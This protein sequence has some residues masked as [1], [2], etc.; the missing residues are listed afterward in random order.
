MYNLHSHTLLSDGVLL[1]SELAMRHF[2]LGYKALA[3]TDHVDYSNIEHVTDSI[4]R[5][6]KAW[7]KNLGIKVLSGI[8]LTHLPLEQVG[9]LTKYARKKGIQVIVAHGQTPAEPVLK[10][11]NRAAIEAGI[12]ILAHPGQITEEE[13]LLAKK[14]GVFLEITTRKGH[15]ITNSHVLKT[16]LNVGAKIIVNTDCHAPEDILGRDAMNVF[17]AET[18]ISENEINKINSDVEEHFFNQRRRC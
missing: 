17:Y 5:F 12:D 4:I 15:K 3:I 6:V 11:F 2:S 7:P 16:A 8:E 9:L 18:G 14:F 1:P 13:V 10:G